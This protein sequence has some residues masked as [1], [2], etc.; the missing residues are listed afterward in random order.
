MKQTN[1]L[2]Y[3]FICQNTFLFNSAYRIVFKVFLLLFFHNL[4]FQFLQSYFGWVGLLLP[5]NNPAYL[6]LFCLQSLVSKISQ[7]V[8]FHVLFRCNLDRLK[9]LQDEGGKETE[10]RTESILLKSMRP[11]CG[12]HNVNKQ[13]KNKLLPKDAQE[14]LAE[15]K[16]KYKT[17]V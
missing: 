1:E 5:K 17:E 16:Q 11:I 6:H 13:L 15:M 10:M 8:N 3:L 4:D 2:K 7:I 9:L 12:V 14:Q